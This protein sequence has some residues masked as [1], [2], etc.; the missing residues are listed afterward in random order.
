MKNHTYYPQQAPKWFFS[1][2]TSIP[3]LF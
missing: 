2:K 1:K 3:Y